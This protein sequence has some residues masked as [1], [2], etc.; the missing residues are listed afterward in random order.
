[1]P[2]KT[3]YFNKGVFFNNIKRFWLIAFA[4][5]FFLF[6]FMV[7]YL[8]Y[9]SSQLN[10]I[11]GDDTF[12]IAANIFSQSN[13][14]MTLFLGFFCLIAALAVF[15]YMHFTRNTA[16]IHSLPLTRDTLFTTNYLSGLFLVTFP[17]VFNAIIL[18]IAKIVMGIPLNYAFQWLGVNF[19]LT[20]LLYTFAVFAGMF[21]GH[22]AAQVFYYLIF[23]FL[24][25]FLEFVINNVL[26]D[27]LYGF[28]R[29]SSKFDA[30]SPIYHVVGL[31][32]GFYNNEGSIGTVIAYFIA[33]VFFLVTGFLLYKKR[34]ME[35]A[36][37]VISF[38][39][40]KPIFKYSAT[41]CSSALL[42][43]IMVGIF[44]LEHNLL[45]YIIVYLVGGF[46]GY[47][48]CEMLLR[49]TFRVF[50]AYKGFLVYGLILT[51][52][53]C[54]VGFDFFGYGNY[55]P[56]A[57]E[58]EIMY[59]YNYHDI[60]RDLALSPEQYDAARHRYLIS[61]KYYLD[62]Y[63]RQLDEDLI[64]ELRRLPG[65]VDNQE[66]IIKANK[67]HQYIADN[68]ELFETNRSIYENITSDQD[69]RV[70][71]LYF[72]YKLKDG[73]IIERYYPGLATFKN[74]TEL[75]NLLREYISLPDIRLK[76]EPIL[77]KSADDIL[78]IS[79]NYYT[80]ENGYIR[81]EI[82]DIE[83]FL[84]AYKKDIKN[85]DPLYSMDGS[86]EYLLPLDLNFDFKDRDLY[87]EYH[88]YQPH[89][90]DKHQNVID[91]LIKNQVIDFEKLSSEYGIQL[92]PDPGAIIIK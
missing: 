80:E 32:N 24:A 29:T 85:V 69:F 89:I 72:R 8:N 92:E 49:K 65:V 55:V 28:F 14:I 9:A 23:N 73:T 2:S 78:A 45:G 19:A 84:D 11:Y 48:V 61:S 90:T 40:V 10:S 12:H 15:S 37:D 7:G 30:W 87:F 52:L 6:L 71:S 16:M 39:V 58:I 47:F 21:T 63:P 74:N 76:Y 66:A 81:K 46:I 59:M 42:G 43:G 82:D 75:D 31:F 83:S 36:T 77:T 41:F 27:F 51:L 57:S 54:S 79:V 35:V 91:Y 88:H 22:M 86:Y 50:N 18:I 70:R 62:D 3:S 44:N 1:M 25:V 68:K 5:T 34:H 60:R 53:L 64:Q 56:D 17:I 67:I 33:G 38:K 13:D 20:F 4:Y 26:S